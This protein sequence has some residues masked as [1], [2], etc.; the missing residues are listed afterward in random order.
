MEIRESIKRKKYSSSFNYN[1]SIGIYNVVIWDGDGKI[2]CS[3]SVTD[4][5]EIENCIRARMECLLEDNWQL[6]RLA[7]TEL[8]RRRTKTPAID[9]KTL[10]E[11][12]AI[13]DYTSDQSVWEILEERKRIHGLRCA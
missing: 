3:F 12:E 1:P 9:G 4:E 11:A 13:Q 2:K 10:D 7:Y 8:E 6:Y 5:S